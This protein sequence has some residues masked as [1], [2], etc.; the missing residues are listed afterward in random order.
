MA[1]FE[2][3]LPKKDE[4]QLAS[5]LETIEFMKSLKGKL[6]SIQSKED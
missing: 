2:D 5:L 4:M 1:A 3:L 6:K